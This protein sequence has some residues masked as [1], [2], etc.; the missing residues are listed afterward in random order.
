MNLRHA[1]ALACAGAL[2]VLAMAGPAAAYDQSWFKGDYWGG[3]YPHGF[4]LTKNVT[5]P[6]RATADPAAA[7]SIGCALKKGA[8]LHPWNAK[9]VASMGLEFVTWSHTR[10]YE[11]VSPLETDLYPQPEG[12]AKRTSLKPG[13]QWAYLSYLGEGTFVM[14][15][16]GVTYSADQDL[17]DASRQVGGDAIPDDEWMGLTCANGAKGWLLLRDVVGDAAFGEPNITE[18]GTAADKR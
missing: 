12:D 2:A 3:E 17:I 15:L 7:R 16:D 5:T 11:I 13:D 1:R 6:I 8:T 9:R 4:T 14:S 10:T 18:Y